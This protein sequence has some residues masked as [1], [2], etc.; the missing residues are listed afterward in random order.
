M[1]RCHTL[2]IAAAF[3]QSASLA[4]AVEYKDSQLFPFSAQRS[5]PAEQEPSDWL[6]NIE[7]KNPLKPVTRSISHSW[8]ALSKT[9]GKTLEGTRK[10]LAPS[11]KLLPRTPSWRLPQPKFRL[12]RWGREP[13][14]QEVETVDDWLK[15]PQP[16]PE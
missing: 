9:S 16:M 3:M 5:E 6:P 11:R 12:P 8:N 14:P 2:I 15:L 10:A 4:A 1:R 13:E 7:L